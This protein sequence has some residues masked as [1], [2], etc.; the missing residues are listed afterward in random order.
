MPPV[1]PLRNPSLRDRMKQPAALFLDFDGT[2]APIAP[3]PEQ[4]WLPLKTLRL[5]K[6]L[7]RRVPVVIVSG[8]S[9][10]DIRFRV[11]LEGI[12]YAG[13]H[14][15]E[16]AGCGLRHRIGDAI[17]WRRFLK[18]VA[19]QLRKDLSGLHGILFEDKGST[20]SVHYRLT[21]GAVRRK[22]A[23]LFSGR[24]GP[25]QRRGRVR[26]TRGKAVWEIRPPVE[27][28]K[29]RAVAWIMRQPKFRGRWPIYIGDDETDQDAFRMIR[30]IG[31]GIAVGPRN[32]KGSAHF[33]LRDP[34]EVYRF[35]RRV[36]D[37]FRKKNGT[38]VGA[39]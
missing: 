36:L 4:A 21:R 17:H 27:W 5:L 14:G 34:G 38:T 16:I 13:N 31:V 9:L 19:E 23:R 22:A 18:A 37:D 26:I 24:M 33:V 35:L 39:D 15:L 6:S 32:Q 10:R 1:R 3:R 11:G 7:S 25:L 30:R 29:G 8:R 20:L 2:L 12:I 28:D